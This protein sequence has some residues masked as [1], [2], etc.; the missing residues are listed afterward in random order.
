[1]KNGWQM[2]GDNQGIFMSKDGPHLVFDIIIPT[3][4]GIRFDKYLKRGV[5]A[6]TGVGAE[7]VKM[8]SWKANEDLEHMS[9]GLV[10]NSSGIGVETHH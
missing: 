7:Q 6:V 9:G 8:L 2:L 3:P 5:T 1:M 10:K 4:M